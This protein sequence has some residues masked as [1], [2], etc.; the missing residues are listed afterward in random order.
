MNRNIS[1]CLCAVA[2]LLVYTPPSGG[3]AAQTADRASR[4]LFPNTS[5]RGRAA[6][7]YE[8][9]A[10]QA[11]AAYYYSQENHDSR[12]LLIE[13]AMSASSHMRIERDD[14]VLRRPDGREIALASQRDWRR[15]HQRV[16]P[17]LQNAR[18]TRQ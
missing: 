15:D 4:E 7:E 16:I 8:D 3:P 11:V 13:L 2:I 5:D 1:P 17:L 10:L 14:I 9:D 18:V 6:V 12:W